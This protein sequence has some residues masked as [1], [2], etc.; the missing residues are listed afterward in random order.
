MYKGARTEFGK[1]HGILQSREKTLKIRLRG[2]ATDSQGR[3]LDNGFQCH[4]FEYLFIIFPRKIESKNLSLLRGVWT[5][6]FEPVTN[7]GFFLQTYCLR[8][9]ILWLKVALVQVLCGP[10]KR[11]FEDLE[12]E[13]W[14]SSRWEAESG[15]SLEDL[16]ALDVFERSTSSSRSPSL[17]VASSQKLRLGPIEKDSDGFSN[18]QYF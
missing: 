15:V 12:V 7:N 13:G 1:S 8:K 9:D 18:C 17:I 10:R 6:N 11:N 2:N 5:L 16:A 3:A 4:E 14:G